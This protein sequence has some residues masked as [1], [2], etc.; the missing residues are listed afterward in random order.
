MTADEYSMTYGPPQTPRGEPHRRR[1]TALGS[2][3]APQVDGSLSGAV[4]I[5]DFDLAKLTWLSNIRAIVP[6]TVSIG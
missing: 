6:E 4:V 5:G 2:G 3:D 1:D